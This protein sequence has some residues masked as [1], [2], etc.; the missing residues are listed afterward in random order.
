MVDV[1]TNCKLGSM[2]PTASMTATFTVCWGVRSSDALT[3]IGAT[4]VPCAK[5]AVSVLGEKF[6]R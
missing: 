2:T 6:N 4:A 3:V 5:L 1:A